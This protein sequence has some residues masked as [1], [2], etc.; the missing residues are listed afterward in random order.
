VI[1]F[2]Y[3]LVL[4]I[5]LPIVLVLLYMILTNKDKIARVFDDEVLSKLQSS[6]A[7]L[8]KRVRDIILAFAIILIVIALSRP[9]L[10]KEFEKLQTYPSVMLAIDSSHSMFTTDIFPNRLE[11]VKQKVIDMLSKANGVNFSI[12]LFDSDTYL[13]SPATSNYSVLIQKLQNLDF[14]FNRNSANYEQLLKKSRHFFRENEQKVIVI[15]SDGNG[16]EVEKLH[17]IIKSN[18]LKVII[19]G[20]GTERGAP[21]VDEESIPIRGEWSRFNPKIFD[22]SVGFDKLMLDNLQAS[23]DAIFN[24]IDS[25]GVKGVWGSYDQYNKIELFKPLLIVALALVFVSF[26][27]LPRGVKIAIVL[28]IL[29]HPSGVWAFD[30]FQIKKAQEAYENQRYEDAIKYYKMVKQTPQ[31]HYNIANSYYRLQQYEKAIE[32]YENISSEN[33]DLMHKKHH[34]IGNSYFN[35]QHYEK[36]I[37]HY[38]RALLLKDDE[39]TAYNLEVA[40]RMLKEEK[41]EQEDRKDEE[42]SNR[43]N[44]E[45]QENRKDNESNKKE[46]DKEQTEEEEKEKE[47]EKEEKISPLNSKDDSQI[48][49]K[50]QMRLSDEYRKYERM[51]R[52]PKTQIIKIED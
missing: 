44:D 4:M 51:L 26:F 32:E 17:K 28:F 50:Q 5:L 49:T 37:E 7:R 31:T 42:S 9:L 52:K 33:V 36:A 8:S 48:Q 27:S 6:S 40:K 1:V 21:L 30:Y 45:G 47:V 34:N 16:V 18:N 14:V 13:I 24:A 3:P 15:F 25:L 12:A 23:I 35:L 43:E 41:K 10:I 22:L 29:S 19:V 11:F 38:E 2:A 46:N 20:V 39:Q